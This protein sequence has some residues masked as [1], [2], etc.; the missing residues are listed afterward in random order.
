MRLNPRRTVCQ[1]VFAMVVAAALVTSASAQA[2]NI[3][4]VTFYTV[5]PDRVGDFQAEIKEYNA[6]LAK[7]GSTH[8]GSVWVSLTGPRV[9]V[10]VSYYTK[11]ADLDA[12]ADPKMKEQA[13]DLAR[14]GMRITNCT[15]SWHRIIEEVMPDLSLPASMEMPKM[16]RVL[17][18]Q[19]RPDKFNDYLELVKK[20]VLPAAQKG[21]LKSFSVA[22]TRYGAP[23]TEITSVAGLN[24]WADLDGGFGVEKGLGKEGYQSLLVKVR[25]LIIQSDADVYRFQPDLSYLPPATAK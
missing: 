6:V 22:Q 23:S 13:A 4:S 3:R 11:W 7:G 24:N 9:Y 21:G 15:D 14:I 20:E 2:G 1:W 5:K 25:A 8:Y 10:L 19:V 12:G 16:I 17:V 18:T